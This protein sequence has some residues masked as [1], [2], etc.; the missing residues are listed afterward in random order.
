[1]AS[2]YQAVVDLAR[3]PLNDSDKTRYPDNTLLVLANHSMLALASRRSDLFVG[4]F[5]NLPDG[6]AGLTDAFPLPPVYLK[7]LADYVTALAEM[8]DDEHA[9]SGRA[10]AFMQLLNFEVPG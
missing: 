6:E 4:Q 7:T 9:Q 3:I 8:V 5:D 2:T 1:M 10:A